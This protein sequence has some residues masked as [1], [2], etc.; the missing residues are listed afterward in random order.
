MKVK[1][2]INPDLKVSDVADILNVSDKHVLKLIRA[3]ELEAYRPG[4]RAYR[5]TREA[6]EKY[7]AARGLRLRIE[8]FGNG[9][10]S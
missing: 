5:V 8:L 6:L 3:G 4:K 2:P 7:R 1:K 9:G 10:T